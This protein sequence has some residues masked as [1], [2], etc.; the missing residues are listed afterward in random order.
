MKGIIYVRVSS[1]EQVQGTSLENQQVAC[2]EYARSRNIEV[3]AVFIERGESA[4]A[5]NRTELLNALNHCRDHKDT[6]AFIV[7]KIDRFSRNTT[8][9]YAI[10]AQLSK[11]GTTLHSVTEPISDDPQGKLLEGLLANFAE[12]ENGMRKQRCTAG[13][14]GALRRGLFIWNSKPGYK[15]PKKLVRRVM[16]P[17]I[18]DG[19]VF[20]KQRWSEV[21]EDKYY[22]GFISDP[23]SGEQY[24]GQHEPLIS[25]A[26]FD[27]IQTIKKRFSKNAEARSLIN[28]EF[29]LRGFVRCSCCNTKLTASSSKGRNGYHSYYH[30]KNK[31]CSMYSSSIKKAE[32]ESNFVQ[33]LK[34]YTPK[35]EYI[36]LFKATILKV[37]E[38]RKNEVT[39]V[40]NESEEQLSALKTRLARITEMR[41]EGDIDRDTYIRM[42][43]DVDN[44]IASLEISKNESDI[45]RLDLEAR[46]AYSLQNISNI[47][48][49]WQ[50]V[51]VHQ[52]MK[53]QN[54]VLPEGITYSKRDGSFGTAPLAYIFRL[55]WDFPNE[56]SVLV[57]GSGIEPESGGY[58]YRYSFRYSTQ[59]LFVVWTIPSSFL[60]TQTKMPTI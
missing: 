2:E 47:V 14:Q 9:H 4:M 23:W 1:H 22:A 25:V 53:L 46:I 38:Q 24:P 37:W 50:D 42:R 43:G 45:D 56:E 10:R 5:A 36:A 6:E 13:M 18:L 44:R 59:V 28:P 3:K 49:V 27:K 60:I 30:C 7:W 12:F 19:V 29:P 20:G 48:R 17:D 33:L 15:R 11:Y 40:R 55:F 31:N 41:V 51:D 26:I 58:A 57:A 52:K 32:I 8:D 54:A 21:L 39:T 35:E 16:E 34:T